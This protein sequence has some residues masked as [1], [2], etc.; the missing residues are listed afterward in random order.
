M[1]YVSL[2]GTDLTVSAIALGCGNFGGIGSAPELF[3]RG[4]DE[5]AAFALLDAA[6]DRG[7]TLVD[8]ANSYGGGRS[9]EWLGQWLASRNGAR[10]E[11]VL[12][13]KVGNRVGPGPGNTGLG[14]PHIRDQVEASLRRLGTDRIDLYLAHEP[15]PRTPMDETVA[16][17]DELVRAGKVRHYGLSNYSAGE[18]AGAIEAARG[19]GAA[20]PA[21]LQNG[22]S[23]LERSAPLDACARHGVAFTA[24]SPLAGGWLSGKYRAGE[25]YPA[26]S[27]MTLRPQPY[28][29][30]VDDSTFRAIDALR[31]HAADRGVQLSTLALAWV[32]AD[33]RVTAIV[34]GP[35][36]PEQLAPAVDAVALAEDLTAAD[37]DEL[38]GLMP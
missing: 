34:V 11:L 13:T 19:L 22:Y 6:R 9:E 25:S 14:A 37:R 38:A 15:D 32:L 21:N 4:D 17:F 27:R 28:E 5:A 1:R 30:W 23:L 18:L 8:T 35:R 29:D 24:Y 7:I 12:T 3:G 31:G 26:G 33:P 36:S 2:A 16:A 20:W 10:D